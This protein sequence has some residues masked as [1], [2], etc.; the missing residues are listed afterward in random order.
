M[1]YV[2]CSSLAEAKKLANGLIQQKLAACVNII[3]EVVSVYEWEGKVENDSESVMLI[4]STIERADEIQKFISENHS[5]DEPAVVSLVVDE[6]TSSA[7]F[8]QWV[9]DQTK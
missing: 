2:P 3:P 6:N 4:K 5:Y 9:K 8:M 1:T 7:S